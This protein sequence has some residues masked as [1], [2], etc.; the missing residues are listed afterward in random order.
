M[1]K[2]NNSTAT[3]TSIWA[4]QFNPE[5]INLPVGFR[6]IYQ[7]T[8]L[9]SS[10]RDTLLLM[11]NQSKRVFSDKKG[12]F[13]SLN[14]ALSFRSHLLLQHF[15]HHLILLNHSSSFYLQVGFWIQVGVVFI[16]NAKLFTAKPFPH[17]FPFI[18]TPRF[19]SCCLI[20]LDR[21]CFLTW[22]HRPSVLFSL[23]PSAST[24]SL[25]RE[26]VFYQAVACV[27]VPTVYLA[28]TSCHAKLGTVYYLLRRE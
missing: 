14:P 8:P 21:R 6:P 13:Y 20:S 16:F 2:S 22:L 25:Q 9:R 4:S 7:D 23:P 27:A 19:F 26:S 17:I 10:L 11:I 5:G 18:L 3:R 1:S 24:G 15:K 28:L 12:D